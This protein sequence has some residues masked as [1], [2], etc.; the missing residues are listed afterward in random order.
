MKRTLLHWHL[1]MGDA[2]L[3]C[4]LVR[5]LVEDRKLNLLLPCW[6]GNEAS[7]AQMF[8]DLVPFV[9]TFAVNPDGHYDFQGAD[10]HIRIGNKGLNFE[11]EH[12]DR[13]FYAQ[14]GV[15]FNDKWQRFKIGAE[16][17]YSPTECEILIHDDPERGFDISGVAGYRPERQRTIFNAYYSALHDAKEIHCINSSV[18]ILADLINTP[19]A[20][21]RFLHRYARPDGGALPIFGREWTILDKP[22]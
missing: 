1:G 7:I 16:P 11:P 21:K 8:A 22:L 4:G 14:A 2:L 19:N 20:S 18:A 17:P 5:S 6:Q 12:F 10:S 9:E 13:S 15:P 3:C